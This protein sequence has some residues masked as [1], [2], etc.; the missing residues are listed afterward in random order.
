[1]NLI[2]CFC[3]V[4]LSS[5]LAACDKEAEA[6]APSPSSAAVPDPGRP[7]RPSWADA[8]AKPRLPQD[9]AL[10]LAMALAKQKKVNLDLFEAPKITFNDS[11]REWEFFFDM[12]E[13]KVK[14]GYF[15]IVVDEA[16]AAQ[17]IAGK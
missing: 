12:K 10:E 3:L 6:P 15:T 9:R 14:G 2:R 17:M 5:L 16:G 7:V 4:T 11:R 13:P 8:A 1:M